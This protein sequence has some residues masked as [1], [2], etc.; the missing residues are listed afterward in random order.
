MND[1]LHVSPLKVGCGKF[2]HGKGLI[3]LLPGEIR[4]LGG[5]ALIIG[6]PSSIDRVMKAA[7][8]GLVA[9]G[10]SFQA[11]KHQ[12]QCTEQWAKEYAKMALDGGYT[13]LVGC[14][15]GKVIDEVKGASFFSD[16][17]VITV[18][19]SLATCVATSMVAIMYNDEGQRS[20]AINLKKEVDVCIADEDLIGAAPRRLLAAGILDDIAKMPE[21]YHKKMNVKSYRDCRLEEYIQILNSRGIYEF[22]L[23]EG[24]DL[25]D[26]GKDAKR[27][28]DVV[29]TN[30][31]HTSI[32]SGFADGSGQL[33]IAHATYDFMRNF[34]T[35]KAAAFLHGELVAVGLMIQMT[36]NG[37][38]E[39]EIQKVRDLMRYMQMP[40][41]LQD[42]DFDISPDSL[43]FFISKVSEYSNLVGAED[44][45]L[46]RKS[47]QAAL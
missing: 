3:T 37:Y 1:I 26:H 38:P 23:G 18:P 28:H 19:T 15:G 32:V 13:V 22:L 9:A 4:R 29:L 24:R 44:F 20:P 33:A 36:F 11:I 47:V 46:L 10:I 5:K 25:Y 34:N 39:S 8:T 31:L 14:G 35:K 6:G 40:L 42:I 21:S 45:E 2:Y 16:L 41:T 7:E 27:F 43:N 17:P 30:L 12:A